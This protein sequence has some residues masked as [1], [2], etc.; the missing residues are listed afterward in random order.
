MDY[1]MGLE[2]G[3]DLFFSNYE[4]YDVLASHTLTTA[5]KLL[6]RSAFADIL[7]AHIKERRNNVGH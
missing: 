2:F 1:G 4:I 3:H 6:K 7:E 5:Y